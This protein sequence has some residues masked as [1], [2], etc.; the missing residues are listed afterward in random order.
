VLSQLQEVLPY[1]AYVRKKS[2]LGLESD[3]M[4]CS[5]MSLKCRFEP[6]RE[7]T[8]DEKLFGQYGFLICRI[9]D[10]NGGT[11]S[12][13]NVHTTAGGLWQHPE[14]AQVD[15]IRARQ[16]DQLLNAANSEPGISIIAGDLNA[17]PNVSE[18]NFRQVQEA[19]YESVHDLLHGHDSGSTWD[20]QN[21]LNR[22]GPHRACP[23]QR[24]DHVF[25]RK[26]DLASRLIVPL[27]SSIC[28]QEAV[29]PIGTQWVTVSDHFGLSVDIELNSTSRAENEDEQLR[30][31]ADG[32][33]N[34]TASRGG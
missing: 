22:D 3:L 7:A 25:V 2:L 18:T 17:G 14:S 10:G 24:I 1:A 13:I 30:N 34:R 28:F 8:L 9:E 33:L 21:P 27:S 26:R 12:L 4:V 29:V 32:G 5:A 6:F 20:P 15:L 11:W 23:P 31:A 19:G 16:I